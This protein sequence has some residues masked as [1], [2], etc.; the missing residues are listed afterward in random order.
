MRRLIS[1][2]MVAVL[3]GWLAL[4]VAGAHFSPCEMKCCHRKAAP[5]CSHVQGMEAPGTLESRPEIYPGSSVCTGKCCVKGRSIQF[6]LAAPDL[7]SIF[8][9]AQISALLLSNL[10]LRPLPEYGHSGRA[11]PRNV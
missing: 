8:F 7:A 10:D 3:A 1:I 11:P 9:V 6:G 5:H 4:P 2:S